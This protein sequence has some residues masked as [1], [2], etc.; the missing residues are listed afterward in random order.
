VDT[1]YMAAIGVETPELVVRELEENLRALLRDMVCGHIDAN[2]TGIADD[3]LPPKEDARSR[4]VSDPPEPS[5]VVR[6][7]REATTDTLMG[8]DDAPGLFTRTQAPRVTRR[9]TEK[10]PEDSVPVPAKGEAES[11]GER[12]DWGLD[13]DAADYSAAV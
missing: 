4:D 6:R 7:S 10:P 1:A 2:V 3:L 12:E 11:G 13:D 8:L 5:F 9:E